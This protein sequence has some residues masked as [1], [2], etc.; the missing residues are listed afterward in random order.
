[1]INL[2]LFLELKL[3]FLITLL[4]SS[5]ISSVSDTFFIN[6]GSP[7]NV[8]V[9][10]RTFVS[11]NNLVQG[12][13]VGTTDSNSGD[14]STL[15]Q[16]ARVFSDES[17]STYRFPIEEHGWFLI[18][19]YFL[20]LVSASQD[21]TTARFSVS[22]QNFT[23]I[24][25]YKPSTTSVVREY[26]LNV[27]TDSLLLQFLPRTGSVSFINALE[28]L[29]LPETLIPEDAKLIGTQKDLKLSSHAMETVSRV[30][31]GNLSVS[32][33]QD[34]LWRQWDSDSAYKAHF[35]TP[36]MNLKAVNFSA[37][38]ITDDIAPVYVYG[39]A[40]RLN[41]D[42]DPNTN[43]NLTWTFKV[44]PGFDYF[45]RFHFCNI[46]VDPFGFERQIR[47]DIFVNSEKVRTIDM[48]EVLNG[49][50]GAPFFVDAVMRK[51]K[52]REGFLNLSIGLVM[53]VSSYP[54]SFINGFEISKLSND[55]RSLD[56]FDA[57]LPDGSSSNKSSNTSVGLIAGLSAALCVAL[58]FG[59]VVSW[60]CIRK[61]RRR[62]RQMQTVHSRG[63][64]HQIKKNETGESLIFSSSKIGYRYPL[65]LIKEA[66][67]D[68]DESLV[69][70]V[71]G[72]GKVYKGVLRDKTEVAVKRGAPQSRQGLAE[73]K[74]EVEMLT[75]FRHRHLVSLIGYCDENSE[76]IIVYEY[77]EK[78]TLKDHLYDLDDKPRLS[79]RQRLE[80]CVGAARGL[81]YLHTGSTR[82]IIHR[83]V[84]SANILL[85]DNFMAKVADFGLSKTGPDLDQ[86]HVSTAVKGSFGYLDPE[87]L[88]RQQLTEKSDVYSFGVVML[89]VVCGRPVIDPSLPRE[90]VNLIE[91]AMKLVKKGK[92]EDIIDPFLVGKVKLEEV[93]KYC[94][95]TEKC[96]SQNGIERPAMGD[97]LWNLE[98]MLQVQAKDEKAAMVDD[99]PEASV[100]GSTMQFSVNGVGD[101]AGVSMSKVFAQMVREETR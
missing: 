25:E 17:S 41:S 51:A 16:T 75:Q 1:M 15:F 6:C 43:A 19:I 22:A 52:S 33:D 68:F 71:G 101:I 67:A 29:R 89:E 10:N 14:E 20:P 65:A 37:G 90:K 42:L 61:R 21:L 92:L 77:M 40:T 82:A 83:D 69:I 80:I 58:V 76:M 11:D 60:W 86:T 23:L 70:G 79:W 36:V 7:T 55:K 46:I 32:R 88:T 4:C 53:D 81:H 56:A 59:V 62:N 78:G 95:I 72:F 28:V 85:D 31:M 63:D 12:F 74:T 35:G 3:C 18:R 44:E 66:T 57:I 98:F 26:I 39:T 96:L 73:F 84:K 99:K 49:T 100:V 50:F 8:T 87:Y 97:L 38:G 45:V 47:F 2:K 5:H 34:K 93:K 94:E 64:D 30:N 27:T 13:S 9:N 48:T 24:R 54:V 91:W